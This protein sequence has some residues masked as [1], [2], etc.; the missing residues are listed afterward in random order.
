MRGKK[1]GGLTRLPG[2][3]RACDER[4][5]SISDLARAAGLSWPTAYQAY[6]GDEVS[7]GTA[8]KIEAGL[9]ANPPSETG[10]RLLVADGG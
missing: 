4:F 7:L 1:G 3:K 5:W 8:R 10:R 9:E 6:C 2:L